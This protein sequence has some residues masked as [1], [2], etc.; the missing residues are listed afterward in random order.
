[1]IKADESI[2]DYFENIENFILNED[3]LRALGEIPY[4]FSHLDLLTGGMHPG[5]LVVIASRP[6]IGK[7][8]FA[9]NIV[10]KGLQKKIPTL[11]FSLDMSVQQIMHRI[12]CSETYVDLVRLRKRIIQQ[13]EMAKLFECAR[14]LKEAPLYIEQ[15]FQ[16]TINEI[17]DMS[18][19]AVSC[20]GIELIVIDSLQLIVGSNQYENKSVEISEIVK[21]LKKM[22]GE[23]NIPVVVLSQLNRSCES[24]IDRRPLLSDLRDSGSIEEISDVVILLYREEY[25]AREK[26][27]QHKFGVVDI[28]L[29]K[30]RN[31]P[32]GEFELNFLNSIARFVEPSAQLN[33]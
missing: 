33:E 12:V 19:N 1:M 8:A 32:T 29:A 14:A 11:I 13:D 15:G 7:T 4:G 30:N 24:R 20:H 21:E 28:I 5:E 22:S 16:L 27:P 31:G 2:S 18:L 6:A 25:Y 9:L 23:L 3:R 26:T 10:S 17:V